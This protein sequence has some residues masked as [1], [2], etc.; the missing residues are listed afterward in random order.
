[1]SRSSNSS[2]LYGLLLAGGESRRMGRNKALLARDGQGLLAR[3]LALLT[4]A[5]C[6]RCRIT[7][8]N[9]CYTQLVRVDVGAIGDFHA[10]APGA[11]EVLTLDRQ[12]GIYKKLVID[13]TGERL[14]GAILVGDNAEY[15]TLLQYY[16]NGVTLPES[17]LDLILGERAEA[18]APKLTLPDSATI[19]SC[20]NVTKSYNFV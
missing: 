2:P 18:G 19:C 13:E 10:Q 20:H 12:T 5:G 9:V 3:G 15:D 17:P 4:A 14:L 7:S 6:Q 16:L 8:Y 11:R 1:M